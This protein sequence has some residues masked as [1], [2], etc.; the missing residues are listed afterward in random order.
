MEE[1]QGSGAPGA[2]GGWIKL[3]AGLLIILN[4]I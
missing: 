2:V 3:L 1:E 4:L